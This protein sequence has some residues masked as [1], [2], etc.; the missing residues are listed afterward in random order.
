MS[1]LGEGNIPELCRFDSQRAVLNRGEH[2]QIFVKCLHPI[3][4]HSDGTLNSLTAKSV[5]AGTKNST[6]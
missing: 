2:P 1:S 4:M 5:P 3:D 6:P